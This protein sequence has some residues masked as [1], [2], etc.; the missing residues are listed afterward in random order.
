MPPI[1]SNTSNLFLSLAETMIRRGE[2]GEDIARDL[3][4]AFK[5]IAA[6]GLGMDGS[7]TII[8]E[9]LYLAY[10]QGNTDHRFAQDTDVGILTDYQGPDNPNKR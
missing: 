9:F 4:V 7:E 5:V 10:Q 8:K 2:D 1:N 3:A 6:E